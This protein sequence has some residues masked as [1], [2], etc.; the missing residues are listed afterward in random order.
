VTSRLLIAGVSSDVS[1]LVHQQTSRGKRLMS[2]YCVGLDIRV[3]CDV[4]LIYKLVANGLGSLSQGATTW[5]CAK[6]GLSFA[7]TPIMSRAAVGAF[8]LTH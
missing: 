5:M 6:G 1:A 8:R 4:S 3:A 2:A 7:S